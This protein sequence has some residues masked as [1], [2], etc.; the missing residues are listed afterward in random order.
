[1]ISGESRA[2]Q[3]DHPSIKKALKELLEQI[4]KKAEPD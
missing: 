2:G 3:Y 4:D 1:V